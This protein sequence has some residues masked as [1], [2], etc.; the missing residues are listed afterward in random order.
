MLPGKG[1]RLSKMF[2]YQIMQDLLTDIMRRASLWIARGTRTEKVFLI[3]AEVVAGCK[4]H[5]SPTVPTE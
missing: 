2:Q 1:K 4:V 3:G 5:L